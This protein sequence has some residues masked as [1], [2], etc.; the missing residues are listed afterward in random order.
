MWPIFG[1]SFQRVT[2]YLLLTKPDPVSYYLSED[3][4]V[5]IILMLTITGTLRFGGG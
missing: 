2:A 1:R 5:S 3:I 4:I